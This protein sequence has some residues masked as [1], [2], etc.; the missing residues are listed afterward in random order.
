MT[1]HNDSATTIGVAIV[2]AAIIIIG[3]WIGYT[4][5][6]EAQAIKF[7]NQ[8]GREFEKDTERRIQKRE[9][10]REQRR[11]EQQKAKEQAELEKRRKAEYERK[12]EQHISEECRFWKLQNQENPT[13][14]TVTKVK[15]HCPFG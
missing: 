6:K 1:D 11:Y 8:M 10:R 9:E 4:E 13:D 14:R 2:A 7:L 15:R 3:G 12:L 5:Y